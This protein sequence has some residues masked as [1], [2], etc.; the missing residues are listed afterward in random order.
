MLMKMQ[1]PV[2][3]GYNTVQSGRWLPL[4]WRKILPPFVVEV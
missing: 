2:F 3:L 1:V 4:F